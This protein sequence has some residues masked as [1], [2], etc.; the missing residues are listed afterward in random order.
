MAMIDE[1]RTVISKNKIVKPEQ[2]NDL[3]DEMYSW[4]KQNHRDMK[5]RELNSILKKY[6]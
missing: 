5:P 2:V 1:I 4:Y 6:L 3:A